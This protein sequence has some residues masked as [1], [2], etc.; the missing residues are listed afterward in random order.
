MDKQNKYQLDKKDKNKS[1]ISKSKG[2]V[3]D[4]N[5]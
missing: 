3:W 4:N 2:D 1:T 5:I